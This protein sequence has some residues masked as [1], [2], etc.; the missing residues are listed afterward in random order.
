MSYDRHGGVNNGYAT[1]DDD[2]AFEDL[3]EAHESALAIYE[4][5]RFTVRT[6]SGSDHHMGMFPNAARLNHSC[7]PN[8]FHRFNTHLGRLTIHALRDI[9]PG[10]ELL[11][12]YI[13]IC[14]ATP[15]RRR[16]LRHWGF[17]CLC[18]LCKAKN[19]E[20]EWRRKRLAELMGKMKR[21]EARRTEESWQ[22]W[23]FAKALGV[24]EEVIRLMEEEGLEESDTLGEAYGT[25]ADYAIEIGWHDTAIRWAEKAL[26][27]ERK[28]CGE[29]SPEYDKARLLLEYA[30]KDLELGK[31]KPVSVI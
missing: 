21:A 4:T 2:A 23:D 1:G 31:P 7:R 28:C 14:A 24:A 20:Q 9:R 18:T 6:S 22:Q 5:N 10:E 29:D 26:A 17:K 11:T 3:V 15:E 25:A 19:S 12:S 30:R 8:V 16:V 13:D 27:I